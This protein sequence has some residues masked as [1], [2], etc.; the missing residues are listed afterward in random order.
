M[1][2][3]GVPLER[4]PDEALLAGLMTGDPEIAVAFVRRF[5]HNIFGVAIAV[6]GDVQ[7]AE[8]I[9]QQTYER[10]CRHAQVY[11]ARRGSVR[12]W[13]TAIAHNLAIDAVRTRKATPVDPSELAFVLDAVTQTPERH[14]LADEASAELRGAV[15][16]LP[17]GQA[18]ALV[19]A[20]I[21][22]M[23]AQQIADIEQVPLGT[24]KTR[25]RAAM[26]KVRVCLASRQD[27]P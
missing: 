7:L 8:D 9:A 17:L 16:E 4:M 2:D 13:L 18:R 27:M 6:T 10:A 21:Y 25:I 15:A 24:A 3:M 23:T 20:G 26:G 19:M 11:D 14:A 1:R 12:T 5:Q 22:G